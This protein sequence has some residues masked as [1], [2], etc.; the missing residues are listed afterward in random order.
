NFDDGVAELA[1][2]EE[3]FGVEAPALNGLEAED[4]LRG[5]AFEGLEAALSVLVR[6][7]HELAGDPVEAAAEEAA[8]E[9]LVHGLALFFEP[10]GADRDVGPG[11]ECGEETL[12]FLDG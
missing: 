11:V 12:G 3:D 7:A 9:R 6:E 4:D 5:L 2:D 1:G 10:A 8:V